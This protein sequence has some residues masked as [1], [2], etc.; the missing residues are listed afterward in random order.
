LGAI[1]QGRVRY[2][3]TPVAVPATNI[4]CITQDGKGFLWVGSQDG[5]FRYDSKNITEFNNGRNPK[6]NIGGSDIRDVVL[7]DNRLWATSTLGGIHEINTTIAQSTA[8]LP[9]VRFEG[10]GNNT[11]MSLLYMDSVVYIGTEKGLYTYH[12]SGHAI[13]RPLLSAP[14]FIDRLIHFKEFLVIC[15]RDR[16]FISYNTRT[17]KQV[18]AYKFT[19]SPANQSLRIYA[20]AKYAEGQWLLGTSVGIRQLNIDN[21]GKIYLPKPSYIFSSKIYNTDIYALTVDKNNNIWFSNENHLGRIDATTQ[22]IQIVE[23]TFSPDVNPLNSVYSLFCDNQNNIWLGSQDGLFFLNNISPAFVTY[24]KSANSDTKIAHAYNLHALNDSLLLVTAENGLY[25][26]N[27]VNSIISALDITQAYDIAFE[28]PYKRILVS[29]KTGLK[30]LRNKTLAPIQNTYN[31]FAAYADFTINSAVAVS[32]SEIVM[33]T[34]NNHGILVW[35]YIKHTA[36]NITQNSPGL[37]LD[38]NIIN[39]IFKFRD[40]VFLVLTESSLL[41]I[42]LS[43]KSCKRIQLKKE[44]TSGEYGLFFDMCRVKERYYLSSYGNGVLELDSNFAIKKAITTSDGLSNNSIYKLIPWKDSLL[45]MTSN[46]GLS[47]LDVSSGKIKQ[48]Y[49]SDGLHDNVFEETSGA[50]YKNVIY[51]GGKNGLTAIYPENLTVN[52]FPPQ[53]YFNRVVINT[54][55]EIADTSNLEATSFSIP[56]NALQTTIYFSGIN[57]VNSSR[58]TFSYRTQESDKDWINLNDVNFISFIDRQPGT[59]HIEIKAYNEDGVSSD[60]KKIVLS[61]LPKWNQTWWFKVIIALLVAGIIYSLYR[62]R[63]NQIKK[64]Q[65]IRTKLA[66]DLHDDLGSSMNSV[67]VYANLAMLEKS[68]ETHLINIKASTQ[69]AIT[70]IRDMIWVLDDDKD[71]MENLFARIVSFSEPICKANNI[72]F[73]QEVTENARYYKLGQEEKRNL[74]MMLKEAVNN[75]VKYSRANAI[76]VAVTLEGSKPRITI[77]DDGIGFDPQHLS[78]GN[79][80]KNLRRRAKDIRYHINIESAPGKGTAISLFKS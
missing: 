37:R 14:V 16:G 6:T 65:S 42:D 76:S 66:S 64:E 55:N 71:K 19:D 60:T 22:K 77:T 53:L 50:I 7:C 46:F 3:I 24:Y 61:F 68:E 63:L 48:F 59:Y 33:G 28:D 17:G 54:Q 26:I 52:Q 49:K 57:F 73:G 70:G 62:M 45:F 32:N 10:L 44:S 38:N 75:A 11:I 27:T 12:T 56:N 47:V 34:E 13:A 79:G 29:N 58:T 74:Y 9:Q 69:E 25:K 35:N 39:G 23:N 30:E 72:H 21:S 31:E 8:N 41:L 40:G 15:V 51:A 18:D 78:E 4:R 2:R 36:T 67:K 80:I 43:Q 20:A 1:S 5:L